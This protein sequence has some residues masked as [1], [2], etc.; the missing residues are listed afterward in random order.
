M[1]RKT[2]NGDISGKDFNKILL[3]FNDNFD[4]FLESYIIHEVIA[5]FC[6]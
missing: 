3:P 1:F 5:F 2:V 6:C 4:E